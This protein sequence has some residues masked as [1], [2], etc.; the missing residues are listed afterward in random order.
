[1]PT[2]HNRTG[3]PVKATIAGYFPLKRQAEL[4]GP[5][6]APFYVQIPPKFAYSATYYIGKAV[7]ITTRYD[8]GVLHL[9]NMT[10]FKERPRG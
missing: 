2:L 9:T 3:A 5:G 8:Q 10:P 6:S 1:M 4:L 7:E